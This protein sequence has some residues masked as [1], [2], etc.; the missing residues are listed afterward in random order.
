MEY[1]LKDLEHAE[2][3]LQ[4]IITGELRSN[5][6]GLCTG[7][8]LPPGIVAQA[9]LV[10]KYAPKPIREGL[11]YNG[12]PI[13]SGDKHLTPKEAYERAAFSKTM[14]IGE[15]GRRRL[16]LARRCLKIVREEIMKCDE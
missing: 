10:W 9:A 5:W 1:P 13:L 4:R 8:E 12:Y 2:T 6:C 11:L 15:Y 16:Q 7:A 3:R 14:Y